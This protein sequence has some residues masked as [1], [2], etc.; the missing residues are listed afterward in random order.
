MP[1]QTEDL[2]KAT[3]EVI[4]TFNSVEETSTGLREGIVIIIFKG[5]TILVVLPAG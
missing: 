2:D 4:G 3:A 1:M 5:K